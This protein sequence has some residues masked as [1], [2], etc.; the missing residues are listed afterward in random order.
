[1]A[2]EPLDIERLFHFFGNDTLMERI[3]VFGRLLVGGLVAAML[4]GAPT[5]EAQL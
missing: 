5:L 3:A 4:I 1:M 2:K